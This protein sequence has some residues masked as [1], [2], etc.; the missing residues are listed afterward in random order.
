MNNL[1]SPAEASTDACDFTAAGG[2]RRA[3][4]LARRTALPYLGPRLSNSLSISVY[5]VFISQF[6][7]R[8]RGS[9]PGPLSA[10][11]ALIQK[12]PFFTPGLFQRVAGTW[13]CPRLCMA[14]CQLILC[15]QTN[16][17]NLDNADGP[18]DPLSAPLTPKSSLIKHPSCNPSAVRPA[19]AYFSVSIPK[20]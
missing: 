17:I 16:L 20:H 14:L 10:Q 1:R 19:P 13:M 8:P 11:E 5:L 2:S 15:I 7:Q 18:M 3:G 6:W 9:W 12:G 4:D